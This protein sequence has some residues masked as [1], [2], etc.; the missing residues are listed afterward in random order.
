VFVNGDREV[1]IATA[2]GEELAEGVHLWD[3]G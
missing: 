3:L 2:A 1:V